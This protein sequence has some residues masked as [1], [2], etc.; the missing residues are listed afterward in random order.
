MTDPVDL[1]G[2]HPSGA[3]QKRPDPRDYQFDSPE[4]GQA[5]A[6]FDWHTGYDVESEVARNLG[7]GFQLTQKDQ[8]TSGS[9]GGQAMAYYGQVLGAYHE[10]VEDERSAKFLYSQAYVL[11]G[12]SDD[13]ELATLTRHQGFGREV[14]TPSY[15]N[16]S[17]PHELF[18]ERPQ[19][20]TQTARVHALTK[21]TVAYAFA[22]LTIDAVATAMK[23]SQGIILGVHGINNGTWLSQYP[24]PPQSG[25]GGQWAHYMYFGKAFLENGQ[26]YLWGKQ[27]WG[28]GVGMNGWQKLGSDYFAAHAVW[29]AMPLIYTPTPITLPTKHAFL[30]DL[31]Q[32]ASGDEVYALQQYL[33][34]DGCFNLAPT[35]TYGPVTA[36][37]IWRFQSKYRLASPTTISQLG[38]HVVGPATRNKLNTLFT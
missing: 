27:S 31:K 1:L 35:G 17:A 33:A 14:D 11:G 32:G 28:A 6:P 23:A 29:D 18:M 10:G 38:G 5:T 3:H 20:I 15:E 12:G 13:R 26:K 2:V 8:G 16:G 22:G 37:A 9:C 21:G 25:D 34:Y 7:H 24:K 30:N 19:D 36:Q 4:I